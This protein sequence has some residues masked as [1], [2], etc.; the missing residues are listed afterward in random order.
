MQP[1]WFDLLLYATLVVAVIVCWRHRH[2]WF[3]R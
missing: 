3:E 1:L 2:D